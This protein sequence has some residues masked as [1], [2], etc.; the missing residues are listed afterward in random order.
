MFTFLRS[1]LTDLTS[2]GDHEGPTSDDTDEPDITIDEEPLTIDGEGWFVGLGVKRFSTARTQ[3]LQTPSGHVEGVTWHWTA[4]GEGTGERLC[5]NIKKLPEPGQHVG[6]WHVLIPRQGGILQCA[7]TTVGTW[8][9]GG[10]TAA[11]FFAKNH[12]WAKAP[13]G[14]SRISANAL[15]LGVELEC[16]GEVRSIA[17]SW[18]GWPFGKNG[19]KGPIV[20]DRDIATAGGRTYQ[21]FTNA[22]VT[23]ATRIVRALATTYRLPAMQFSWTH[24]DIDPNRKIDPGPIWTMKILPAILASTVPNT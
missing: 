2:H 21:A 8:H 6:S 10:P 17:G 23:E 19:Q 24:A 15:F 16:V 11:R 9:A 14:M 18:M 3:P 12:G 7:P 4:T 13:P 22:Q 1:L 5:K 20:P